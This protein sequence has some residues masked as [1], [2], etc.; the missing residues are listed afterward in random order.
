M[1][2]VTYHDTLVVTAYFQS[3]RAPTWATYKPSQSLAVTSTRPWPWPRSRVLTVVI[4]VHHIPH[5]EK[6]KKRK[7]KLSFYLFLFLS[8]SLVLICVLN[9]VIDNKWKSS[10][11]WKIVRSLCV[12]AK[13]K[14]VSLWEFWPEFRVWTIRFQYETSSSF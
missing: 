9:C 2:C 5:Q 3:S 4:N 6:K 12:K 7:G 8:L 14:F 13:F 10:S 11:T 1:P